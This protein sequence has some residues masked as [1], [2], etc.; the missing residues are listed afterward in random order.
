VVAVESEEDGE[1][2][3]VVDEIQKLI[4]GT[5]NIIGNSFHR[6]R[7][8]FSEPYNSR[9][10]GV[11]KCTCRTNKGSI[12]IGPRGMWSFDRVTGKF[13]AFPLSDPNSNKASEL[14]SITACSDWIMVRL[15]HTD[16]GMLS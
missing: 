1:L 12:D 9:D 10:I 4:D 11:Y 8:A 5:V 16:K 2:I 14:K 6:T 7:S 13:F 15:R 3:V